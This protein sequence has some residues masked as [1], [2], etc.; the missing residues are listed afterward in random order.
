MNDD[1]IN[2]YI[3]C[4]TLIIF[5]HTDKTKN[6]YLAE[7]ENKDGKANNKTPEEVKNL[8][9]NIKAE[10]CLYM[11]CHSEAI[12]KDLPYKKKIYINKDYGIDES[13]VFEFLYYFLTS[14]KTF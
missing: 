14:N 13:A 12:A 3:T 4:K 8:L 7:L 1:L 10:E 9:K 11:S 5:G 6:G 2:Y